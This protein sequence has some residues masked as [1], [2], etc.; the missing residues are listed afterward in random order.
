MS[1]VS[2]AAIRVRRC[3]GWI[4]LIIVQNFWIFGHSVQVVR[5]LTITGVEEP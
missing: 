2:K 4:Q 3:N 1:R 5:P